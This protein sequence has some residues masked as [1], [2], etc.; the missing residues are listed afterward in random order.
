MQSSYRQLYT[1]F[2]TSTTHR[3]PAVSWSV[4]LLVALYLSIST[5]IPSITAYQLPITDQYHSIHRNMR[6]IWSSSSRLSTIHAFNRQF[7]AKSFRLLSTLST[8][9][10]STINTITP[11]DTDN[12]PI[13]RNKRKVALVAGYV[14]SKYFGLQMDSRKLQEHLLQQQPSSTTSDAAELP[15][16][17]T[18][19]LTPILPTIEDEIRKALAQSQLISAS[20]SVDLF[21]INWSRSS[22]TD[23]GVH[24]NRIV[25]S[26]K[27]ELPVDDVGVKTVNSIGEEDPP[28]YPQVIEA[29]N[30]ILPKEIQTFSCIKVNQGFVARDACHWRG[31]EYYMPIDI[32]KSDSDNLN[33]QFNAEETVR[34]L[35]V[36]LKKMEGCHSFHNFHRLS[37]KELKG[38]K[39]KKVLKGHQRPWEG[40]D[41]T[42]PVAVS[43]EVIA[44]DV[45]GVEEEEEEEIFEEATIPLADVEDASST[46]SSTK[47]FSLD[48]IMNINGDHW[49]ALDREM[50]FRTKGTIYV[51]EASL[52]KMQNQDM[53]KVS[54]VGQFFLLQ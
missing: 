36:F 47:K 48:E 40:K 45:E 30:R 3:T 11:A 52:I 18:T 10:P 46:S 49:Q 29:L 28:R 35:N 53:V 1:T 2:F 17:S 24:A 6:A 13:K 51:C 23:K 16:T 50:H 38:G 21:K 33:E 26:L 42:A 14:G 43:T 41:E 22:R 15:I 5:T 20:N 32:L 25:F 4:L 34:K 37:V 54:I 19:P 8:S 9:I 12:K 39:K 31:Y 7:P 44:E 27:I